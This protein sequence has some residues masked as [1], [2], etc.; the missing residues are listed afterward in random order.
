[1]QNSNRKPHS[2]P[3]RSGLLCIVVC[4]GITISSAAPKVALRGAAKKSAVPASSTPVSLGNGIFVLGDDSP[5]RSVPSG[6][7]AIHRASAGAV[8][9]ATRA[10]RTNLNA[11]LVQFCRSYLG[12]KLGN[13]QC[14]ELAMLG[15]PAIGAQMD[16]NNQWGAPVCNYG[17]SGGRQYIQLGVA[18]VMPGKSRRVN[19]K[20]GDLIQYENV[21]FERHWSNGA[22]VQEYPHHTSV[23]ESVSRDGHTLKV[24]EQNVNNTQFVVETL[25]YLPDQTEGIMHISRPI[26]R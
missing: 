12:R 20:A 2:L 6:N 26:P 21:K 3:S 8:Q 7:A 18:G 4:G 16:L 25:L 9:T 17:V 11:S 24:L 5:P 15:L 23:I 13:G 1:M 14:S 19:I 22:S 10:P